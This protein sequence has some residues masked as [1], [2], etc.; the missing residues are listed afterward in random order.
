MLFTLRSLRKLVK[1][2]RAAG[3]REV[4][5]RISSPPTIDPCYYGID[6]PSKD[7]LIAAQKS[8]AETASYIGVDSLEYLS[9]EGLYRAV[10]HANGQPGQGKFCDACFTGLYPIG[11]PAAQG[12]R[13][14]AGARKA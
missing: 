5:M 13:Q 11:T 8:V 3:A 10:A 14:E 4:H 6:T 12:K 7:E 1:M 9:I 2:L